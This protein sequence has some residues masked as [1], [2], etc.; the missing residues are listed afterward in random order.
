M[1]RRRRDGGGVPR[2]LPL[3]ATP[4]PP[5]AAAPPRATPAGQR[6]RDR[7]PV[8]LRQVPAAPH[9]KLNSNA[10]VLFRRNGCR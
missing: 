4:H 2:P 7:R 6:R 8:Q 10:C 5:P 3:Y 1:A 9:G